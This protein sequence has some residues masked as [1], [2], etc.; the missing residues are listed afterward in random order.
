MHL[1][2]EEYS[3]GVSRVSQSGASL[4]LV[5]HMQTDTYIL[6][7][8]LS[9]PTPKTWIAVQN[10]K[11]GKKPRKIVSACRVFLFLLSPWITTWLLS[12]VWNILFCSFMFVKHS[13]LCSVAKD[14]TPMTQQPISCSRSGIW[15]NCKKTNIVTQNRWRKTLN[16]QHAVFV[17]RSPHSTFARRDICEPRKCQNARSASYTTLRS[18][19]F[20]L[21]VNY[22]CWISRV[23]D[24]CLTQ[25]SRQHIELLLAPINQFFQQ[26]LT[27]NF[28][29][30]STMFLV[31]FGLFWRHR[32]GFNS[33]VLLTNTCLYI[34]AQPRIYDQ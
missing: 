25:F 3:R 27:N 20:D 34:L 19:F 1:Q 14:S 16:S 15:N 23:F 28:R 22:F 4:C 26:L 30:S 7:F 21:C 6:Q 2:C 24:Q 32:N 13:F 8:S 29:Q 18:D 9:V 33:L 12:C 5:V 10:A 11:C 17:V 31:I